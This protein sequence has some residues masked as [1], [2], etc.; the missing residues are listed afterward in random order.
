MHRLKL[1]LALAL[2]VSG[3]LTG[4]SGGGIPEGSPPKDVG[5]VPPG[6]D[7]AAAPPPTKG[8]AAPK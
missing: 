5:Y 6:P 8:A 3:L 2:L 4:C 1:F 7:E